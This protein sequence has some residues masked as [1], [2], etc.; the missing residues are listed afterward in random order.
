MITK[1][2]AKLKH[3]N[4][5]LTKLVRPEA[6]VHGFHAIEGITPQLLSSKPLNGSNRSR[7]W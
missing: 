4:K 5:G 3:K 6:E 1:E 2:I 7:K